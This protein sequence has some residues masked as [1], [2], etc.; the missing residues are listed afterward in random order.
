MVRA[1]YKWLLPVR[2]GRVDVPDWV[3][4]ANMSWHVEQDNLFNNPVFMANYG[5]FHALMS[6]S[7]QEDSFT[8]VRLSKANGPPE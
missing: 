8:R 5:R 4:L 7:R 2:I 6:G 3:T 1:I